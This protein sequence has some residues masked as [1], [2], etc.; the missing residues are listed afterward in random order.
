VKFYPAFLN[1]KGKRTVVLGGGRVAERKALTL[2][3]SGASVKIVSPAVT[4]RLEQLADR[5]KIIIIKRAFKPGDLKGAFLVIAATSSLDAN[6]RAAKEAG[7][8]INVADMP[9]EGN[10]IAPSIIKRGALT[11]A[12]STEGA[13]PALSKAIRKELEKLY[14]AEFAAYLKFV[15]SVRRT[16]IKK[17]TDVNK[18]EKFLRSL[19]SEKIFTAIRCKGLRAVTKEITASLETVIK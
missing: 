8:L 17:I 14:G 19:A 5:G 4:S 9:S 12:I 16:A 13:S 11:I 2:L 10:F 3:K 15:E 6:I 7:A 18:R 1:L